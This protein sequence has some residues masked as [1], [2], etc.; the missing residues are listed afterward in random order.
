MMYDTLVELHRIQTTAYLARIYW[1]CIDGRKFGDHNDPYKDII[2][3]VEDL[4]SKI[5]HTG[6]KA[7]IQSILDKYIDFDGDPNELEI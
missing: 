6:F 4:I 5:N 2:N 3:L 7:N 1:M